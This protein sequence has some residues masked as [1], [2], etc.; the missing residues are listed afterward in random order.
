MGTLSV[1]KQEKLEKDAEK[2]ERKAEKKAEQ[3]AKKKEVGFGLS[4]YH[5]EP[6]LALYAR[7]R[8]ELGR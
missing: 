1:E 3:E 4:P 6:F 8:E 7:A 5:I 2:A